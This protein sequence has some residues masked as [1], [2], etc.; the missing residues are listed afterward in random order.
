[1]ANIENV[2]GKG[3]PY[4]NAAEP[5]GRCPDTLDIEDA[6]AAKAQDASTS[7]AGTATH[8]A[9]L[10]LDT[11]DPSAEAF[12]FLSFDDNEERKEGKAKKPRQLNTSWEN[13]AAQLKRFN[14]QLCGV[15]VTV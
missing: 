1:M 9:E 8:P 14:D 15:F 11:L 13:S 3:K 4:N 7:A 12:T 5:K 10:F 6:I 2:G